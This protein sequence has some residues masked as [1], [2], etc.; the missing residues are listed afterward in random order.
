VD[1]ET[2]I[3][4]AAPVAAGVLAGYLTGGSLAGLLSIRLRALWLLWLAAVVQAGELYARNL[5]HD[6]RLPLLAIT[7]ALAG[8]WL[9][10]NLPGR[11]VVMKTAGCVALAGGLANGVVIV[12]NGRM[13]YLPAAARI[14]QIA[15]GLVTPKNVAAA[16][17]SHLIALGDTIPVPPLHAI[18]SIGDV[19]VILATIALIAT[20]MRTAPGHVARHPHLH[21]RKRNDPFPHLEEG[22]HGRPDAAHA[23]AAPVHH[24]RGRPRSRRLMLACPRLTWQP[25]RHLEDAK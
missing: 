21:R 7:F 20:A 11:S 5:G 18:F 15:P 22:G 16:P 17:G 19:L 12:A 14:A 23:R 3:L 10:A 4:F 8:A 6:W 1:I 25:H 2:V 13:P 24:R 9:V